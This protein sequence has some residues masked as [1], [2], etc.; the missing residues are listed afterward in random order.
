MH[1]KIKILVILV[2]IFAL[3]Q[4]IYFSNLILIIDIVPGF[5]LTISS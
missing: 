1:L 4:N 5:V 2:V 3:I